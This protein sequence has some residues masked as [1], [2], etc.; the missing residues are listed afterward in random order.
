MNRS[1]SFALYR[2]SRSSIV[3]P[4][5]G[6]VDAAHSLVTKVDAYV[7]AAGLSGDRLSREKAAAWLS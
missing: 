2:G 3:S 7:S 4:V 6:C 5:E 1:G